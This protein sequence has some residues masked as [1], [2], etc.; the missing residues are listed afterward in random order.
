MED[1]KTTG[2]E[3]PQTMSIKAYLKVFEEVNEEVE[4]ARRSGGKVKK[5]TIEKYYRAVIESRQ[6]IYKYT[7][8]L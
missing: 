5:E 8:H 2:K 6:L 7:G 3:P 4:E 1:T